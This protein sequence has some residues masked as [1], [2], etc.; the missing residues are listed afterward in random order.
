[1]RTGP[2]NFKL[3]FYIFFL[4][5]FG[6]WV[7]AQETPAQDKT[8]QQEVESRK[9]LQRMKEAPPAPMPPAAVARPEA[10][11]ASPKSRSMI[12]YDQKTGKVTNQP[13]A[14]SSAQATSVNSEQPERLKNADK[15][16]DQ[17]GR[18]QD[19]IPDGVDEGTDNL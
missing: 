15:G 17:S 2:I 19:P 14:V 9:L 8:S 1:M 12:S 10:E 3:L 16:N 13:A 11:S 4:F 7:S 6:G 18:S 5:F